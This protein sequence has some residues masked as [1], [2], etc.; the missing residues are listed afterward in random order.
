MHVSLAKEKYLFAT[1]VAD[2]CLVQNSQFSPFLIASIL[3]HGN[4][5][6]ANSLHVFHLRIPHL[7][8]RR[9]EEKC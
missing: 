6:T 5:Q 4:I 1:R 3:R 9:R 2:S 8:A 7:F